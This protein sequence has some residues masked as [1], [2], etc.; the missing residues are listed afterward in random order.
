MLN[1]DFVPARAATANLRLGGLGDR[2]L[3]LTVLEAGGPRSGAGPLGRTHFLACRRLP[4][5]GVLTW[6]GQRALVSSL[7][8]EGTNSFVGAPP[9]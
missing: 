6:P 4:S 3:F 9:P 5:G 2:R 7:P 1:E 8:H